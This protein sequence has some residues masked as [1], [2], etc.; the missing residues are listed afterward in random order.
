MKE[1]NLMKNNCLPKEKNW[2]EYSFRFLI[3]SLCLV[4]PTLIA[5][6]LFRFWDNFE[7]VWVTALFGTFAWL[8]VFPAIHLMAC[9]LEVRVA[10]DVLTMGFMAMLCLCFLLVPV[11]HPSLTRSLRSHPPG[12]SGKAL[13]SY[14]SQE[15]EKTYLEQL[16]LRREQIKREGL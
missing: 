1:T 11:K 10:F 2:N 4:L 9:P 5:I 12:V 15:K 7:L 16:R 8:Y 6:S 3:G 14:P 13:S